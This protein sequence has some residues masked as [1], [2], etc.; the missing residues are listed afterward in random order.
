MT[1]PMD[2]YEEYS[3]WLMKNFP[4]RIYNG[5]SLLVLFE[6]AIGFEE[7]MEE[8]HGSSVVGTGRTIGGMEP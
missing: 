4:E 8:R 1:D 7:F 3:E 5:D 2:Y 6:G